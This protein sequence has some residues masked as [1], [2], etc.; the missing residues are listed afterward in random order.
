MPKDQQ[1]IVSPP[2]ARACTTL[3]SC[4]YR[5]IVQR[6]STTPLK[7]NFERM[8]SHCDSA[9]TICPDSPLSNSRAT[10]PTYAAWHRIAE[11]RM[12]GLTPANSPL[13]YSMSLATSLVSYA[14]WNWKGMMSQ[15]LVCR[16]TVIVILRWRC[17]GGIYPPEGEWSEDRTRFS[18]CFSFFNDVRLA[19]WEALR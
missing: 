15:D 16:C 13:N 19:F 17:Q 9:D 3:L 4:L 1:F 14:L 12:R 11:R 8:T 10:L 5:S 18:K 7:R 2:R 6:A